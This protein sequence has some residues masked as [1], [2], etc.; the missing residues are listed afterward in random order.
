MEKYDVLEWSDMFEKSGTQVDPKSDF[1]ESDGIVLYP[2]RFYVLDYMSDTHEIYDS[3]PVIIS[4]G[5]S[6]KDPKSFLCIDL[7]V[8]PLKVRLRFIS[9]YFKIFHNDIMKNMGMYPNPED[10]DRQSWI[11]GFNYESICKSVSMLPLKHA[12]KRYKIE[13][14][15]RIYSVP[16][17]GVYKII[18]SY[19][20]E[21]W[22]VNG[23]IRDIQNEFLKNVRK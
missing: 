2:G 13:N 23:S 11:R 21:D 17:F 22:F 15:R 14:T 3:K 5:L 4:L 8:L 18:G 10:A 1:L 6:K 16:F 19:A 20:D 12:V 9:M 7:R